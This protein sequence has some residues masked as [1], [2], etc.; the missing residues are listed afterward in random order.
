MNE[1][2]PREQHLRNENGQLTHKVLRMLE[3]RQEM[4]ADLIRQRDD[5]TQALGEIDAGRIARAAAILRAAIEHRERT[6][7]R[8]KDKTNG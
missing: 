8:R 2:T 5:M 6:R 7:E 3:Q 1:R 4:Q